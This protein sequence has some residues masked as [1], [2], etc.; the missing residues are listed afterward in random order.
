MPRTMQPTVGPDGRVEVPG[1]E[2]GQTVAVEIADV[3]ESPTDTGPIP[4]KEWAAIT[5][6]VKERAQRMREEL[7][8][9]WLSSDHDDLLYGDDGLPG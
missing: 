1:A 5:A 2:P 3:M 9:P 7:P 8:E 6:R 4:E